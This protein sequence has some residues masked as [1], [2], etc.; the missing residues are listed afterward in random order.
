V[1]EVQS[2]NGERLALKR[3]DLERM[4]P[5]EQE[6]AVQE[7]RLLRQLK[8]PNIVRYVDFVVQG[9][10]IGI[11]MQYLNGGDLRCRI[12]QA[13]EG[14]CTIGE[15]EVW[16]WLLQVASA[17]HYLHSEH[18][19][20][21]DVKPANIFLASDGKRAVLGDLGIARVL[22]HCDARAVTQIGTPGYLAPEVWLGKRYSCAA[23]VY[24]LGCTVYELV[25]LRMP[26][27]AESRGVLAALVLNRSNDEAVRIKQ[28]CTAALRETIQRMLC[29]EPSM[30]PS[31]SQLLSYA[32][33][34]ASSGRCNREQ[35]TSHGAPG[36]A[37]NDEQHHSVA[38]TVDNT[39][40]GAGKDGLLKDDAC[41]SQQQSSWWCCSPFAKT[42]RGNKETLLSQLRQLERKHL[43]PQ[44]QQQQHLEDKPKHYQ[45]SESKQ[46][47]HA[48]V[49]GQSF[50]ARLPRSKQS[51]SSRVSCFSGQGLLARQTS[52]SMRPHSTKAA[53]RPRVSRKHPRRASS[54]EASAHHDIASACEALDGH[55]DASSP[56][57]DVFPMKG[58][59]SVVPWRDRVDLTVFRDVLQG[60]DTE[61]PCSTT[62]QRWRA[63]D[64]AGHL[65][66][67]VP[68]AT[69]R[70]LAGQVPAWSSAA[71]A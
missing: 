56:E 46:N 65:R 17:L 53:P 54:L 71:G 58:W 64:S 37:V 5:R 51:P 62:L 60:L 30:R 61:E 9:C 63:P 39:V 49:K 34:L 19:I 55:Q 24:S 44:H 22:A 8:H 27:A 40:Q 33:Y 38:I 41:P 45:L 47:Q 6:L 12:L 3:M 18:V 20:H 2:R 1:W 48:S 35:T 21:R 28:A 32:R 31:P 70:A 4:T 68:M 14:T 69:Q 7:A 25:E 67:K 52:P 10:Q 59:G 16:R 13:R 42:V 66:E 50:S 15:C 29:M 43:Q 23:D 26:F 57:V 11:V 36:A